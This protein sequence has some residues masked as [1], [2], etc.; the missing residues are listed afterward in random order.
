M[1]EEQLNGTRSRR[2]NRLDCGFDEAKDKFCRMINRLSFRFNIAG[3]STE[4][5]EKQLDD[6]LADTQMN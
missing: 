4:Q 1:Q 6:Q 2:N 5:E 3:G